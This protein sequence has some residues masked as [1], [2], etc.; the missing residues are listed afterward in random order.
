[1]LARRLGEAARRKAQ[2]RFDERSVVARTL[3][4]YAELLPDGFAAMD[5]A[6]APDANRALRSAV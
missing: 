5:V 3:A 6:A 4:V 1:L 2:S